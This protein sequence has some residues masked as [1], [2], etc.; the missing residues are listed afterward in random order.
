MLMVYYVQGAYT[1]V[2]FSNSMLASIQLRACI[3]IQ[4]KPNLGL[5]SPM[6]QTCDALRDL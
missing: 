5:T 1:A 6:K 3:I 4:I 2:L